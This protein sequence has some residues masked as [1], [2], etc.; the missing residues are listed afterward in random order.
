MTNFKALDTWSVGTG[1]HALVGI[2]TSEYAGVTTD[3]ILQVLYEP[4]VVET[5]TIEEEGYWFMGMMLNV[6]FFVG[7]L[8]VYYL[9]KYKNEWE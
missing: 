7:F 4:P 1:Q 8:S 3:P 9:K 6:M 2:R 5:V